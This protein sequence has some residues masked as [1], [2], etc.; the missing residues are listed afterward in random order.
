[1][2]VAFHHIS[3][4]VLNLVHIDLCESLCIATL[5]CLYFDNDTLMAFWDLEIFVSFC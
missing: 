3:F 2:I 4:L 1:M 5:S